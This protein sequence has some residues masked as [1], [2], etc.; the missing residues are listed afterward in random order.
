MLRRSLIL[1]LLVS[2]A[3]FAQSKHAFTFE[4]MMQL[5]RVGEPIL[6]PDGKWVAFSAIDVNLDENART[7]HLWLVPAGGGE[8]R[9]LTPAT[10]P[11]EDRPR[12]SPDGKSIIFEWSKDGGSQVWVQNFDPANGALTG[13]ARKITA[14]RRK[15]P[16]ASGRPT[17]RASCSF[18]RSI[19]TAGTTP[20]T[21]SATKRSRNPR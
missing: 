21:S 19:P 3:A 20:A 10:G 6:S 2:I 13:D 8:A 16:A 4:D 7:P 5:K 12:F 11:G 17:A 15:P 9:R 18:P 14:S 1:I